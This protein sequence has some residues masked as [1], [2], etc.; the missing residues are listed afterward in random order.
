PTPAKR[1]KYSVLSK[2]K[3]C[4]TFALTVPDWRES[5][6]EVMSHMA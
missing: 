2:S 1:P 6:A 3:F 5:L 4:E